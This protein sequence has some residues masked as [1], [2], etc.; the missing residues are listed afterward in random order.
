MSQPVVRLSVVIPT[1]NAA[2]LVSQSIDHLYREGIPS[3]AELIVVDDGSNDDTPAQVRFRFADV[4]V[5]QHAVNRGFGAAVN[6]G[7]TAARGRFLAALNNDAFVSWTSLER[8]MTFLE[9]T[10]RAAAG[11]PQI[12][13]RAGHPQR[14]GFDIP[15]V[16]WRRNL[17]ARRSE[18]TAVGQT[19]RPYPSG[20]LRG[21]C[22]VF[23][24]RALEEV[25]LFD[26]QF[27]M[28][29]EEIDLFQ[30]LSV[31]GW[32][33]WVIPDVT[34][35]HLAGMTTRN[36]PD[37]KRADTFR[38]SYRSMCLY[39]RKHHSR[40]SATVLRGMLA[41]RLCGRFVRSI[42][43][44]RWGDPRGPKEQLACLGAVLRLGRSTPVEPALGLIQTS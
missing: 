10:Q 18:H 19:G 39:Y 3:W 12:L 33:A 13:D 38:R 34:A 27:Y 16:P 11:A 42:A 31:A 4:T 9:A 24:R 14:V 2:D 5:F 20:Y 26:E 22:V 1:W 25:G 6:T 28:F 32:T 17:R 30:R 23:D 43:T 29:A 36:H 35:T 15:S 40:V 21:A 44:T 8:I 37:P 41:T 7:F